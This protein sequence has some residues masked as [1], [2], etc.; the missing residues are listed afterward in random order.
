[1]GAL[2]EPRIIRH[3]LSV[4]QYHRMGEAG[5]LA[6]DARVE[7]VEGE[8]IEMA[9]IDSRHFSAVGRLTRLLVEATSTR[10][11]V[12]VQQ[13]LRLDQYN[14]PE[15]DLAVLKPRADFY[16]TALPMGTDALLVIE[17][18]DSTVAFD[19]RSKARLY[20]A[21]GVPVYW[22]FDLPARLLH[23]HSDPHDGSYRSVRA[24]TE[25]ATLPVPGLVDISLDLSG[26]F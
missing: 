11:C 14:E 10:A 2:E 16:E 19:L 21:N 15:P 6:P 26:L 9:P 18:A 20:A 7:L 3:R 5:V 1:M 23:V 13:P 8:L 24:L 17:V 22:V 4:E 25:P 12:S